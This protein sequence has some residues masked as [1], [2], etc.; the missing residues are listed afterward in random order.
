MTGRRGGE[1]ISWSHRAQ[2][3]VERISENLNIRQSTWLRGP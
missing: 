1:V 3:S 2:P